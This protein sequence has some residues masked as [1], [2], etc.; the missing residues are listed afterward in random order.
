MSFEWYTDHHEEVELMDACEAEDCDKIK[1]LVLAG[2]SLD[3]Q[4]RHPLWIASAYGRLDVVKVI[5]E[6]FPI[7]SNL[8]ISPYS[9]ICAAI[10]NGHLD[11]LQFLLETIGKICPIN[12]RSWTMEGAV[13][14]GHVNI[15]R[16]LD[17][18]FEAA[19]VPFKLDEEK[20]GFANWT[21]ICSYC[22]AFLYFTRNDTIT[23][24]KYLLEKGFT[25]ENQWRIQ[26]FFL[27]LVN[28][29]KGTIR[30]GDH[31]NTQHPEWG[32][33]PYY[34]SNLGMLICSYID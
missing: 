8:H 2:V 10:F 27:I 23:R 29:L 31:T 1:E 9:L 4:P 6:K 34:D 14:G 18:R 16:Y 22:N 5:L 11:V 25:K 7:G 20:W 15:M 24:F 19:G 33:D 26:A 21:D 3:N 13:T 17:Q 32:D 28:M 12:D 30:P